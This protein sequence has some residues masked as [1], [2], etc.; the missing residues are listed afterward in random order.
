[1]TTPSTFSIAEW[2]DLREVQPSNATSP[3]SVT[4]LGMSMLSREVQP[5]NALQPISVTLLGMVVFA[6]PLTNLLVDVSII[7]L[8]LL[9]ES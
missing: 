5:S 3:I 8:Q 1:M 2:M 7:A 6:H 9:R 4:L